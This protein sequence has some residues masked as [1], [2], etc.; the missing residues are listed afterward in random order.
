MIGE[1]VGKPVAGATLQPGAVVGAA[2]PPDA[3]EQDLLV[4]HHAI[5]INRGLLAGVRTGDDGAFAAWFVDPPGVTTHASFLGGVDFDRAVMNHLVEF[6]KSRYRVDVTEE[7][8]VAQRV[9]NAAE[10]A[11]IALS[12]EQSVRIQVPMPGTDSRGHK[13]DLDYVLTREE[14]EHLTAPLVEKTIGIIEKMLLSEGL[15]ARELDYV[16][17]V[18]GQSRMPLVSRRLAQVLG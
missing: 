18:G 14:L 4:R 16:I 13:F 7:P 17:A 15:V 3:T 6:C 9:L 1:Q 5:A 8:V 12:S 10:A 11:K 2:L